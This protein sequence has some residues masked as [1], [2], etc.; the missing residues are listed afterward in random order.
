MIKRFW[1]KYRSYIISIAISLGTGGLA[2][3]VTMKNMNIEE[4]VTQPPGTPPSIV[5]FI[6]WTALYVL[7]G[8]AAA[9]IYDKRADAPDIARSGLTYYACS[10]VVNFTWNILFFNLRAFLISSLWIVLL[11]VLII[12]TALKYA[13]IDRIAALMNVPYILWVVYATYIT[14]GIFYLN[15]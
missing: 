12:L 11:L 10:L 8:I 9:R 3:L 4:T 13:K 5:F 7:M 1:E 15:G 6:V 14:F 2:A